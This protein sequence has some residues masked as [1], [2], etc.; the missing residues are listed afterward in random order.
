LTATRYQAAAS[1]GSRFRGPFDPISLRVNLAGFAFNGVLMGVYGPILANVGI[2]FNVDLPTAGSLVGIHFLGALVG[3]LGFWKLQYRRSPC[4]LLRLTYVALAVGLT[5]VVVAS[6]FALFSLLCI[7]VLFAGV[8]FG[9]LDYG[10]SQSFPTGY[11]SR[12]TGKLNLLHGTFGLGTA[13]GPLILGFVGIARYPGVFVVG[14]LIATAGIFLSARGDINRTPLAEAKRT[15]MNRSGAPLLSI[16]TSL[17]VFI[18]IL[19]IAVQGS[20]GTWEPT[21]LEALGYPPGSA[22]LWTGGFWFGIAAS[23]LA[24]A[25]GRLTVSPGRIVYGCC[26]ATCI[27]ALFTLVAPVLPLTYMIFGFFIGPIFPVGLSWLSDRLREPDDGIAAV[28]VVSMVGGVIFPPLLG[29]A[30]YENGI[31]ILPAALAGLSI[32][33]TGTAWMLQEKR[34]PSAD[35]D[36]SKQ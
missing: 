1:R 18:Y 5:S 3:A 30:I 7:G 28:V 17:F 9:G 12:K 14:A 8:G 29:V 23:R 34:V 15:R 19:H 31:G 25:C 22:S 13:L 26:A 6:S 35:A 24:L 2:R 21:Q 27:T 33:A 11:G 32:I 10:L 20:I 16:S 36:C 4:T